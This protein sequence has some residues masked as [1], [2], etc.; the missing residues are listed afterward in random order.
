M[1]VGDVGG[2]R[3]GAGAD[4]MRRNAA[5][6]FAPVSDAFSADAFMNVLSTHICPGRLKREV[7][8]LKALMFKCYQC[9]N[10]RVAGRA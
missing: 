1:R 7:Q 2:T 8:F 9:E 5:L 4:G 6:R 10:K 3:D